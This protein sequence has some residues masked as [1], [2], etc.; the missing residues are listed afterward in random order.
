MPSPAWG[1]R[2]NGR[3]SFLTGVALLEN[4]EDLPRAIYGLAASARQQGIGGVRSTGIGI[5]CLE[6]RMRAFLERRSYM[7][8]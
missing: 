4:V 7:P 8:A 5:A 3:Y 1:L 6:N 2:I